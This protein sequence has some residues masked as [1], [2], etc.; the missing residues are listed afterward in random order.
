MIAKVVVENPI[1][2]G[3]SGYSFKPNRQAR[4][5][6]MLMTKAGSRLEQGDMH[7]ASEVTV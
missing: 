1:I 7:V 3:H 4:V 2:L 6:G 5:M